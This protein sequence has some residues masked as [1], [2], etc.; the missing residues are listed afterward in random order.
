M[1]CE[2]N[3]GELH[4][5][6]E[7]RPV[8]LSYA[9]DRVVHCVLDGYASLKVRVVLQCGSLCPYV[10]QAVALRNIKGDMRNGGFIPLFKCYYKGGEI[11]EESGKQ[12]KA[13]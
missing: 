13:E 2:K 11:S 12:E 5:I 7:I 1:Y 10:R 6:Q 3:E 8:Y 9:D 4:G